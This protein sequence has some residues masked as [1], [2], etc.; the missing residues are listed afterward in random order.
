MES[1]AGYYF[2]HG[3]LQK[4][5]EKHSN[6]FRT[7]LPFPHMVFDDLIPDQLISA[8]IEEFPA[9]EADGWI[10]WGGGP[11][12][13]L[14][15]HSFE[16]LGV[17]EE[18]YFGPTT[19]HFFNQLCCITFLRFLETLTGFDN[20]IADPS[21]NGCGLHST[22]TG[23]RL[24]VHADSSRHPSSE[25]FD[26]ALN[27]IL[28]INRDWACEYEGCLEL[29]DRNGEA[30]VRRIEPVANRLVIFQTDDTSY[31]GHP[32]PLACPVDRRR[33]SLASYYYVL[34]RVRDEHYSG[35]SKH[36][37]WLP[38]NGH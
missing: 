25:L 5:A 38:K 17:S 27:I 16:K 13:H 8:F 6:A 28:Y 34:N 37:D 36:V 33:N 20:L 32:V 7:A 9:P 18:G 2:D 22:G 14:G 10:K 24:R 4:I 11:G 30:C 26:Q 35:H 3:S 19:R 15:E 31:H 1:I 29:W 23:A 21:F 12:G